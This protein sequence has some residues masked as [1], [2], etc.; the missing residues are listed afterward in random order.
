MK[1]IFSLVGFLRLEMWVKNYGES[2]KKNGA[3][4]GVH[5]IVFLHPKKFRK[6]YLQI[7]PSSKKL[8][9]IPYKKI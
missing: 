5:D 1:K 4:F 3:I 2:E 7:G 9:Q 6:K 8:N